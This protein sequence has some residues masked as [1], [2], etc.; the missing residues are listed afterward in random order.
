MKVAGPTCNRITAATDDRV[1]LKSPWKMTAV[2]LHRLPF[3]SAE[4]KGVFMPSRTAL[5]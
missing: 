1:H 3:K 2:P 5:G 4:P